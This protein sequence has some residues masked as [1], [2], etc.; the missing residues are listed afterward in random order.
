MNLVSG[1]IKVIFICSPKK[2]SRKQK[3]V[4]E[5]EVSKD[6]HLDDL[7]DDYYK[8]FKTGELAKWEHVMTRM[9]KNL[10][11]FPWGPSCAY[12]SPRI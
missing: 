4:K 11:D 9:V 8:D 10:F 12:S 5:T 2:V 7:F 1:M 6:F 3:A